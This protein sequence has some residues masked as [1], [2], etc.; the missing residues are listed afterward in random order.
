[1]LQAQI[2][3]DET[4]TKLLDR[5]RKARSSLTGRE[6]RIAAALEE[7]YP[8]AGLESATALS[9]R[10]GVSAATV[11]RFAA[12][13]GYGGYPDLQRE[14]REEVE[15]R[16]ASP[17]QRLDQSAPLL[18][19]SIDGQLADRTFEAAV[20]AL[21]RSFGA[22]DRAA[23]T[24]V[25]SALRNCSG[26]ILILG[27]KKARSI[28]LYLF[29]Q[30]NLCLPRVSLLATDASFEGDNLLDIGR[31]DL[32]IAM[33]VRRYV[34]RSLA[35]AMFAESRGAG[36]IVLSDSTA[37]PLFGRTKLRL[38]AATSTAGAFDSYVGLMLFADIIVNMIVAADPAAA[39][40][41]LSLGEEAWTRLGVFR[42]ED[43][44]DR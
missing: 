14:M 44:S 28:A 10:L 22:L 33:D 15:T 11:I 31:G 19:P 6:Q 41:R 2:G 25:V 24:L 13:L 4:M 27:E 43:A 42:S 5:L 38:C 35:A 1:M 23:L 12:K 29:A 34:R 7:G 32:L 39:R 40:A 8:H 17:L 9:Q 26:R 30:L 3:R 20:S 36:L 21:T 37:S 18:D 16:L